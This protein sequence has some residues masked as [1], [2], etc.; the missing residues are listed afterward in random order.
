MHTQQALERLGC[1]RNE[2]KVYI[3]VLQ[4]GEASIAQIATSTGLPRST[5]QV[6]TFRLQGKGLLNRYIKQS[7]TV[8]V[9]ENPRRFL[10]DLSEK[11]AIAEQLL[12]ELQAMRR[13]NTQRPLVRHYVGAPRISLVLDEIALSKYPV[14]CLCSVQRMIDTLGE[15]VVEGFFDSLFEHP[16]PVSLLTLDAPYVRTLQVYVTN[17]TKQIRLTD[18][19]SF[20][21]C[22][23]FIFN[24]RVAIVTLHACESTGIIHEDQSMAVS[25]TALFTTVWESAL[26]LRSLEVPTTD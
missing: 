14:Y 5:A 25:M 2:A 9:A 10:D 13:E 21:D 18:N 22:A 7:R 23:Y 3:A 12:P 4:K 1:E 15:Q 17:T 8:W 26:P 20:A 24:D 11:E 16:A 19:E 6:V